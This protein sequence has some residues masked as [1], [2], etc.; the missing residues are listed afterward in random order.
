MPMHRALRIA[1]LTTVMMCASVGAT[2]QTTTVVIDGRSYE[3]DDD[4]PLVTMPDGTPGYAD[5]PSEDPSRAAAVTET[6]SVAIAMSSVE[7][8]ASAS[9]GT[10]SPPRISGSLRIGSDD[11]VR[12]APIGVVASRTPIASTAS[13]GSNASPP[14]RRSWAAGLVIP[15]RSTDGSYATPNRGLSRSGSIWHMRVALNVA[16]LGC[17]GY[18]SDRLVSGYNAMLSKHRRELAAAQIGLAREYG[19][20]RGRSRKAYDDSMTRLYN[21]WATPPAQ[22]GFCR[23]AIDAMDALAANDAAG[24]DLTTFCTR[25][26]PRLDEPFVAFFQ[27]YDEWRSVGSPEAAHG[28]DVPTGIRPAPR[29]DGTSGAFTPVGRRR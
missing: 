15:P 9:E 2:A 27:E 6:D 5:T 23:A 24:A 20:G 16:A 4:R 10:P 14:T 18:G 29:Y 19:V 12:A 21:F 17:R 25:I 11:A 22:E 26:L 7:G 1:A 3:I 28:Q 13:S 8:S